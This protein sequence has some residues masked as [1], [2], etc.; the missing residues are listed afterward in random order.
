MPKRTSLTQFDQL[1]PRRICIIKPS[2]LGD[3]VQ[4]MPLLEPLS[5]RFPGVPLSWVINRELSGLLTGH[6]Q[7]DEVIPFDRQGGLGGWLRMLRQL[8]RRRFDLVIDLQGLLRSA[9]MCTATG[10]PLRI[11]LE[12]ARE[13]ARFACHVT[14][15]ETGRLVPAHARYWRV[16]EA[17]G[18]GEQPRRLQLAIPPQD[19]AAAHKLLADLPRPIVA[20]H[21]GARW[22]T[23]RWPPE[24]FAE[25]ARTAVAEHGAGVVLLGSPSEAS[26]T[27]DVQRKIQH[28]RP[29]SVRDLAGKT[30]LKQ[31]AALLEIA[32]VVVSNDSGPMHLAAELGTPV[33]GIFTCTDP[34]RSG[35]PGTQHALISTNVP[36]AGS[37]KKECPHDGPEHLACFAELSTGRVRSAVE[38]VLSPSV[39]SETGT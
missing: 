2:A 7:I 3:V 28:D 14:L 20:I 31:L 10:A 12:T 13:G 11:G 37:Y 23:K 39:R 30:S 8:R 24:K 34:I 26:L 32:D 27:A 25:I 21:P 4:A 16:A 36:C 38:R 18:A 15:P 6:P 1:N 5:T 9:V 17:L 33:V 19:R 22:E 35:P 29:E